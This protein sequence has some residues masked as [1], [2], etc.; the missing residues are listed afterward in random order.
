MCQ[1]FNITSPC[2][3]RLRKKQIYKEYIAEYEKLNEQDRKK[4]YQNTLQKYRVEQI[5]QEK[6]NKKKREKGLTQDQINYILDNKDL[7]KRIEI[8]KYLGIS[9]DQVSGV[10]LGKYYKDLIQN[11]YS[12]K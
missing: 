5:K 7:Y 12:N 9:A 2:T 8:A 1:I 4:M 11:Y 10:I 6:K 3:T